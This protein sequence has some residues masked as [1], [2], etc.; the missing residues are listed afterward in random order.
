MTRIL[1]LILGLGFL[2]C[3]QVELS[4]AID[5]L[6][7]VD[8]TEPVICEDT[9]PGNKFC[10]LRHVGAYTLS[11]Q[12]KSYLP[13]YCEAVGST[14]TYTNGLGNDQVF[15]IT[16]K[17]YS[18]S[19]ALVVQQMEC[20][21]DST[22]TSMDCI[23]NESAFIMLQSEQNNFE[24]SLTTL[25]DTQEPLLDNVGDFLRIRREEVPNLFVLEWTSITDRRSLS[26]DMEP[27]N[28]FYPEIEL[29]GTTFMDVV[30]F[31][32]QENCAHYRYYINQDYGLVGFSRSD[33]ILWS[34]K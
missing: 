19:K 13:M 24:I 28:K 7:E 15:T 30:G 21:G 22:K 2:S 3:T 1:L 12:S 8:N 16:S 11:D 14:V 33:G 6:G 18:L 26:Y 34:L 27:C 23:E 32:E 17:G 25:P 4:P 31:E 9:I 20:P 10:E 29:N 5:C